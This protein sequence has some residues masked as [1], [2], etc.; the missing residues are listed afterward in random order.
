MAKSTVFVLSV[1]SPTNAKK[2]L[3]GNL[4]ILD[5]ECKVL[6]GKHAQGYFNQGHLNTAIFKKTRLNIFIATVGNS[7][8]CS[9][10]TLYRHQEVNRRKTIDETSAKHYYSNDGL[11]S[12]FLLCFVAQCVLHIAQ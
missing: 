9:I 12:D 6:I 7:V 2:L 5:N 4:D 1:P 10:S 8:N 11:Y 3:A